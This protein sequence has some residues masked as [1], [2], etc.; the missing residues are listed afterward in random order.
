M[1]DAFR[2][3]DPKIQTMD[4]SREFRLY[5][6]DRRP[7]TQFDISYTRRHNKSQVARRD[8]AAVTSLPGQLDVMR[9]VIGGSFAVSADIS[10]T[11]GLRDNFSGAWMR[12]DWQFRLFKYQDRYTKA[13]LL[14]ANWPRDHE[15]IPETHYRLK[16]ESFDP[17]WYDLSDQSVCGSVLLN[18][19]E[20]V[21]PFG[22]EAPTP[23]YMEITLASDCSCV[24]DVRV[25]DLDGAALDAA[26]GLLNRH[27]FQFGDVTCLVCADTIVFNS[28]PGSQEISTDDTDCSAALDAFLGYF[29]QSG[30]GDATFRFSSPSSGDVTCLISVC[31]WWTNRWYVP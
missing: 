26:K 19:G 16:L 14:Q 11:Q 17:Y 30:P 12:R 15:R 25:D 23:I 9:I 24:Q 7:L 1:G 5:H 27:Y 8:G 10:G 29:F 22:G 2:I 31:I 13:R 21:V 20:I 6:P 3:Y 28:E 4:G 18:G